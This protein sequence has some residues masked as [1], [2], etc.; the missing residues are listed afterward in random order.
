MGADP[1][2]LGLMAVATIG[3]GVSAYG[4]YREGQD[5][6]A[7]SQYNANVARE[8]A[9]M[10]EQSGAMDASRQR[11]QVSRLIGTQK[12]GYAGAG[13]ELSGS[14]LDAMIYTAAE[15]EM[16]AQIIEYSSRIKS[17]GLLS[18]AKYDERL[19]DIYARSG[20][21]RAG[22]TLLSQGTSIASQYYPVKGT[23][24][25]DTGY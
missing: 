5:A 13:V 19:G 1:V 16:D 9:A 8:Q 11:K 10:I 20:M 17:Q 6:K 14:P 15:G 25:K 23:S 3:A 7:A 4:S 2:S 21:V 24:K 22:G 18:Q 12:A